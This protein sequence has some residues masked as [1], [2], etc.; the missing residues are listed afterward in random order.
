M[1]NWNHL[2]AEIKRHVV[3][4]L[5]FMSRHSLKSTSHVDRLIVNSTCFKVPRVRFGYK[6]EKCL[7]M[8]YTGIKKFLRLELSK[9][10]E[11]ILVERSEN[12]WDHQNITTKI[13]PPSDVLKTGLTILK[14][15][16]AH[17]SIIIE[18]M[19]WDIPQK[20]E[21]VIHEDLI[22]KPLAGSKFRIHDFVILWDSKSIE[23]L[24]EKLCVV[25]EVKMIRFL[26][27]GLPL[28][29]LDVENELVPQLIYELQK[30]PP[31]GL[32]IPCRHQ[33]FHMDNS[34]AH[35]SHL[36]LR[37]NYFLSYVNI[38]A[39]HI[40]S[41]EPSNNEPE[42]IEI[43]GGEI[44]WVYTSECGKWVAKTIAKNEEVVKRELDAEKC[45]VDYLCKKCTDSF[46]YWYH[47]NLPRRI[48]QEPF[49][50]DI[51]YTY[52]EIR[53]F[54]FWSIFNLRE[55][56]LAEDESWEMED[57]KTS[58]SWGFRNT[59]TSKKQAEAV[60]QKSEIPNKFNFKSILIFIVFPVLF[61]FVFY[62][63]M[64]FF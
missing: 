20:S 57:K 63:V 6:Q 24:I 3:K 33:L 21:A 39:C 51:L 34:A 19:E 25:E 45:G 36:E 46:N 29:S 30:T 10:K 16:L 1:R 17:E 61:S 53:D 31:S 50:N 18:A 11:G 54:E 13:L 38:I 52:P 42:R 41:V 4:K 35:L 49:W 58:A 9:C 47:Q 62:V 37:A 8:I 40:R 26:A 44:D 56:F 2:P 64:S 7:V 23:S 14:N 22:L 32:N 60:I 28:S 43:D 15:L 27:L 55:K 59:P 12:T 5:D 48:M